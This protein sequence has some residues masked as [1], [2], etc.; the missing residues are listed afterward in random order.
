MNEEIDFLDYK[1]GDKDPN[2]EIITNIYSVSEK[3][4]LYEIKKNGLVNRIIKEKLCDA[5]KINEISSLLAQFTTYL[6][7]RRDRRNNAQI[8]ANAI[9][10]SLDDNID[11]SVKYLQG[12]IGIKEKER[13]TKNRLS[14]LLTCLIIVIL[15]TIISLVLNAFEIDNVI[16]KHTCFLFTIATFGSF[17]GFI[18]VSFKVHKLDVEIFNNSNLQI[19][20][21]LSRIFIAMISSLIVFALIKS[22]IVF[23]FIAD[24][25]NKYIY[26]SMAGLSGF[27]EYFIPNM[28]M[29]LGKKNAV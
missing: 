4:F 29:L 27:S 1:I 19:W 23:G 12:Q 2:G 26:Y 14:Y 20:I 16:Y 28:L 18:S 3:Y 5:K 24:L 9:G 13:Q 25:D 22:N 7:N 10:N 11:Y 17:G 21:G 8:V 6:T 15:N